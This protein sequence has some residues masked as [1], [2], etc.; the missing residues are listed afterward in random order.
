MFL[1]G[2]KLKKKE[3]EY[4]SIFSTEFYSLLTPFYVT[5]KYDDY[6]RIRLDKSD[7]NSE[8]IRIWAGLYPKPEM[9]ESFFADHFDNIEYKFLGQETWRYKVMPFF[10]RKD[11]FDYCIG[12]AGLDLAKVNEIAAALRSDLLE[13]AENPYASKR[14]PA[15][16]MHYLL[17]CNEPKTIKKIKERCYDDNLTRAEA[18]VA[19]IEHVRE[20]SLFLF[21]ELTYT[22]FHLAAYDANYKHFNKLFAQVMESHTLEDVVTTMNLIYR[23]NSYASQTNKNELLASMYQGFVAV[24]NKDVEKQRKELEEYGEDQS[25]SIFEEFGFTKE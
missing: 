6:G 2:R 10:I 12:R 1:I 24:A 7:T 18:L 20:G 21:Q 17:M 19:R 9:I 16:D 5:G 25:Y 8:V 22:L 4:S 23:P 3:S 11:I 15:S 13:I 14:D